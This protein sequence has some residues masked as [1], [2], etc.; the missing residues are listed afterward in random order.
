MRW[1]ALALLLLELDVVHPRDWRGC[2]DRTIHPS[3]AG[4][5][6]LCFLP[7]LG[8]FDADPLSELGQSNLERVDE[9]QQEMSGFFALQKPGLPP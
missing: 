3:H 8:E 6:R 1:K 7:Y 5:R 2:A 4:I 9:P